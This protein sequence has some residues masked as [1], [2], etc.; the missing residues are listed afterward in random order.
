MID[1]G[2]RQ[3]G[4]LVKVLTAVA[5][6]GFVRF[7][8]GYYVVLATDRRCLG[9][10]GGHLIY[11][12]LSWVLHP[13]WNPDPESFGKSR[14]KKFREGVSSFARSITDK[15]T[16]GINEARYKSLFSL[17]DL[18]KNKE[19]FFS[20][21]Y[22]LTHTLQHNV[23]AS[24]AAAKMQRGGGTS[25]TSGTSGIS[26]S[27]GNAGVGG[28]PGSSSGGEGPAS[29]SA[30]A[31]ESTSESKSAS[32]SASPPPPPD[33]CWFTD[34][35]SMFMWNHFLLHEF[36]ACVE[37]RGWSVNL[38]HGF[39]QQQ[40]CEVYGKPVIVSLVARRSR[41]FA[42]TRYLKRGISDSGRVANDVEVEQI[43]NG[44][45]YRYAFGAVQ[46]R[47]SPTTYSLTSFVQVR[48]SIP[49]SWS[50]KVRRLQ[51]TLPS[52]I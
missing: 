12:V 52:S 4:G 24:R 5:I 31:P 44:E 2:N 30:S 16:V 21:T 13:T 10:I 26:G 39:F 49:V 51:D 34:P 28:G 11:G 36:H 38:L 6:L 18:S 37:H 42:G 22:D 8:E 23:D 45:D 46:S 25:G 32:S 43:V 27:G 40:T 19:F 17:I 35:N 48:G 3:N 47:R 33:G 7:L 14:W 9:C 15:N 50:Q 29:A 20:Y 41:H 1:E